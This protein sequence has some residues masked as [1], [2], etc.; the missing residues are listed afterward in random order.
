METF[1]HK[2]NRIMAELSGASLIFLTIFILIDIVGRIISK[3]VFGASEM[4]I[5]IM[6]IA[7]YLSLSY[8]EEKKGHLRVKILFS[9]VSPKCKK[10]L[11]LLTYFIEF[12]TL[13][14]ILYSVGK[15]GLSTYKNKEAIQGL[16][17]LVIYPVILVIFISCIFYWIQVGLNFLEKFKE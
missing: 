2:I 14:I 12:I 16:V 6:I 10:M 1:I 13:G 5:F 9:H 15:Y 3:P 11:N 17:P 4:A 7:V 8:C